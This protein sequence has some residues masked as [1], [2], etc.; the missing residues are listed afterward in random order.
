MDT[1]PPAERWAVI[2]N[3]LWFSSLIFSLSAASL[4]I[5]VKQW[6]NEYIDGLSGSSPQIARLRQYRLNNLQKWR[7]GTIVALLPILLQI[8]LLLFFAGLLVL[9]Y[10]LNNVVAIS[11]S[12]LI[13]LFLVVNLGTALLPAFKA[14][15]CYLSPP[16]YAFFILARPVK[17]ALFVVRR[18]LS[19][20]LDYVFNRLPGGYPDAIQAVSLW[21]WTTE[22][23]YK[24]T[25]L[26]SWEM[27]Q[28]GT[29]TRTLDAEMVAIA[30]TTTM[31]PGYL[32]YATLCFAELSPE[33]VVHS[34]SRMH[35][36]HVRHWHEAK[37]VYAEMPAHIWSDVSLAV[38]LEKAEYELT[39][40]R[41]EQVTQD[42]EGVTDDREDV[43]EDEREVLEK[44]KEVLEEEW[45]GLAKGW[46]DLEKAEENVGRYLAWSH[47]PEE[48]P[49]GDYYAL[50]ISSATGLDPGGQPLLWARDSFSWRHIS[51]SERSYQRRK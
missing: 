28:V 25:S 18:A 15:C 8:A 5:L 50:N 10:H 29:S 20:G 14:D 19:D 49:Q 48:A 44:R 43:R 24:Y 46:K 27:N 1:G 13:S 42:L 33:H 3:V 26:R 47:I 36:E 32:D 21:I 35:T 23:D 39:R 40:K 9:L 41:L 34:F 17:A 30:Y 16:A 6:L 45:D 4:G 51:L 22:E 12:A 38:R 2:L 37:W 7:V 31:D 11:S